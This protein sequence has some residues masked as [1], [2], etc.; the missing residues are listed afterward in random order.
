MYLSP[1]LIEYSHM[2]KTFLTWMAVLVIIII[3]LFIAIGSK[4]PTTNPETALRSTTSET[5]LSNKF[6]ALVD[7]YTTKKEMGIPRIILSKP[8]SNLIVFSYAEGPENSSFGVYHYGT[9][10]I[11]MSIG[12]DGMGDSSSTP[13]AIVGNDKLL[14]LASDETNPHPHFIVVNFKN[15]IVGQVQGALDPQFPVFSYA[16]G[17]DDVTRDTFSI[18]MESAPLRSPDPTTTPGYKTYIFNITTFNF[19]EEK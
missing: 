14:M 4:T 1:F 11:F 5:T 10:E 2:N 12:N 6:F 19:T 3:G 8:D 18:V 13:V 17:Y 7:T 16:Y 9:N 15:E